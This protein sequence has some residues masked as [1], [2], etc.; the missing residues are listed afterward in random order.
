M[1]DIELL[2][3]ILELIIDTAAKIREEGYRFGDYASP[4]LQIAALSTLLLQEYR[5]H[6]DDDT[7][8]PSDQG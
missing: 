8:K 5:K 4:V 6:A 2:D 1:D 7:Q 3:A